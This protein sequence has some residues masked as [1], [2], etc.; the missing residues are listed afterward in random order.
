MQTGG[1]VSVSALEEPNALPVGVPD[2]AFSPE[3]CLRPAGLS[4]SLPPSLHSFAC[5]GLYRK[6]Y[7]CFSV[8]EDFNH[9]ESKFWYHTHGP[10]LQLCLHLP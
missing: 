9:P 3:P 10:E 5:S 2:G 8:R 1:E 6:R 4:L 7:S